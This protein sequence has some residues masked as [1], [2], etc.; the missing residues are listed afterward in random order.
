MIGDLLDVKVE[1]CRRKWIRNRGASVNLDKEWL[2]HRRIV[3]QN[4]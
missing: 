4:R 1:R 3:V 2:Q